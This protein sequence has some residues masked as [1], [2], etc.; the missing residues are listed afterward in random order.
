MSQT[1]SLCGIFVCDFCV[2]IF[3]ADFWCDF[4][5][6]IF[7]CGFFV[8]IFRCGFFMRIFGV[9]I[10]VRIFGRIFSRI[11]G[12]IF[13]RIFS[14]IFLQGDRRESNK[15]NPAKNPSKNPPPNLLSKNPPQNSPQ[16]PLRIFASRSS[17]EL[18]TD[19]GSH[20]DA[21]VEV[22]SQ[23]YR[24]SGNRSQWLTQGW[25][26]G[27]EDR[28]A[29]KRSGVHKTFNM[30]SVV[31]ITGHNACLSTPLW[32]RV[33]FRV[34]LLNLAKK[35]LRSSQNRSPVSVTPLPL[36]NSSEGKSIHQR[37]FQLWKFKCHNRQK[38]GLVYTKNLVSRE[39]EGKYVY[40]KAPSRCLWGTPFAQYWCIDFGLLTLGLRTLRFALGGL[41]WQLSLWLRLVDSSQHQSWID[42]S[43]PKS[44]RFLRFA[45]EMPI[46]G[47]SKGGLRPLSVT[48]CTIVCNCVLCGLLF[49]GLFQKGNFV[50]EWGQL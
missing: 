21:L 4:L 19:V 45:I 27:V 10:L 38:R 34:G 33:S 28:Q 15:K 36:S 1:D 30:G 44:Q 39:K 13:S 11:F 41:K 20:L 8:R 24:L 47:L 6:R 18:Q 37:C 26:V 3:G 9:R 7:W 12:R 40:T 42:L 50:A 49:L 16:I 22:G 48:S 5:V 14:R 17:L 46:G 2:R 32:G 43:A 31:C 29:P 23:S 25:Q 35:V